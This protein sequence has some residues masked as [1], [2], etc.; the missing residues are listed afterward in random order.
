MSNADNAPSLDSCGC[1]SGEPPLNTI[2][3]RP[4]LNALAYRLG[5]Y[6]E[7]LQR[8][9][10]QI[11]SASI[12]E[13]PNQGS[14]PLAGL[15][16]RSLDDPSIALLDAWAIVADVLTF[17]QERIA[18]E[19]FLRTATDRRS[20]LELARAIG[21]ELN[22]GVAASAFLQFTVEEIIGSA[23]ATGATPGMRTPVPPGPGSS[24]F[25]S[26]I[27]DIP[28]G[29]QVQSV[30]APGKLPQTFE[31]AGNFQ[32]HAEWNQLSPR[33]SRRAD[34]AL[35]NGKLYLI[36]DSS[37]FL[38]G[39]FTWLPQA[40]VF[41]V[42]PPAPEPISFAGLFSHGLLN[43]FK[44]SVL[45]HALKLPVKSF[46]V[47]NAI[48]ALAP[49]KAGSASNKAPDILKLNTN[50]NTHLLLGGSGALSTLELPPIAIDI[51][52]PQVAAVEVNEI[53]L[54][55]TSTNLKAGDRMLLV[56]T[57]S[58]TGG[59]ATQAFIVRGIDVQSSLN[60]TLVEFTDGP[61]TP[62][63][64]PASF[65][66]EIV[67]EEKIPFSHSAVRTHILE[68][69]IGEGDLQIFLQMNGWKASDLVSMVN[70]PP[71]DPLGPDGAFAFRAYGGFFGHNAPVWKSLPDPA[72]SQR[73]D[74]YPRSW[75]GANNGTGTSVWTD[76]QSNLYQE[77]SVYLERSF[78]QILS[79]SWALFESKTRASAAYQITGVAEKSLSDYSMSGKSTGLTLN[80]SPDVAPYDSL[81]GSCTNNPAVVSWGHDRLDVF[82][83]GSGDHALYHKWW[84]GGA[85]GPSSTGFEYMGGVI[86]GDP[87]AVSWDHDRL[88]VF[89]VGTDGALYHKAW[90]GVQW[91]PSV[92]DYES[93]GI[94]RVGVTIRGNPVAVSWDHDRLDIFMTGT[95]GALYH[96]WWDGSQWG[97]SA[98]TFEFM[99]GEILGD[100]TV[101]SWDHDRLD[102]FV[103]GTDEGLYHKAW[104][105]TRWYPSVTDYENLGRP[106]TG[107][108]LA[109]NPVV[110]SWGHDRLD[111]FIVGTDGALYHKWW[112][113]SN[114][115]P[116]VSDFE[117]MSGGITRDPAVVSWDHDRLDVFVIGTDG[118]L[119]HKAWNGSQWSPS[120]T[121]YEFLSGYIIS[122][123]AVASWDH[124]RLDV[125]VIGGDGAL[126]H[127]AWDGT[128][129][130]KLNFPT[131]KTTAYVQSEQLTLVDFPIVDDISAGALELMLDN[132]V[133][134]LKPGQPVVISG[135]R[136]D[137]PAVAVSEVVLLSDIVHVGG[138]TVLKFGSG[139]KYSYLRSSVAINANVTLATH[140]AT[141]QEVLGNGDGSQ[142]NQ[143]FHLK[144]I[145]LTYVSAPTPSGSASSLQ[146]RV[147]D[148]EWEESE[149]FYGLG[150]ADEKYVVRLADD[151][152]PTLTFGDPAAR[153]RTGQQNIR[154]TYRTG[155]GLS[156]NV[157]AGS[158]SM[159]QSRPPGLRAVT[160][161]LA[162]SGGA[163]P[164][165][166]AHARR[167]APLTVLTLDR[168][169]SLDDYESFAQAFA[170]IGKAQAVAVWS[171]E[172]HLVHITVAQANGDPVDPVSPLY[173]TL[174]QAIQRAH[175]P[176]Q[177]FMVAAYQPL[178][179]NLTARLLI[180]KPRYIPQLVMTQVAETLKQ[181][182]SF[183][184]RSFAQAVTAAEIVALI[185]SVP[186]VIAS[187][188][189]QLYFTTDSS[190]PSQIE[191]PPFLPSVPAG[192]QGGAIRPAQLLLLNHLGVALTE[193]S[194]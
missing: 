139:L 148:L 170:G 181:A 44:S 179:F 7:F 49:V 84:D 177:S 110:N 80:F 151:G 132:M 152:T 45:S 176:V 83:V 135:L 131:R 125:F 24:A 161:P 14:Q 185:Q 115:G 138:F 68:K 143:S 156:G 39:T 62:S 22:P 15:T 33:L 183:E 128:S 165:D 87:V 174:L 158:L 56:G 162:A 4:G 53:Y 114:W 163:D 173:Q 111:V 21:Y 29:T 34:L 61:A 127:K 48:K 193:I 124:D 150:A 32:A 105:G 79:E 16:T 137:L 8:L 180:E 112:D 153:P 117:F 58:A 59:M 190:G 27:V 123:P 194:A 70:N 73:E 77:A 108:G 191:P 66:A 50:L 43:I 104:D 107:S 92:T 126:Y 102:V 81:G 38:P 188:L 71:A 178:S 5:T 18:N 166:L 26:G 168:I 187:T 9:L 86:V 41:L 106:S 60:R 19:G 171:G 109:R 164:Q 122:N 103:I 35:S 189:T 89:V 67:K 13:G 75:D 47:S 82:V 118:A 72:K 2:A 74:P 99:G 37:A 64:T 141:V 51:L 17:Y 11:R 54:Q 36:G 10:N 146:V 136:A 169:V 95:D 76:S 182:F 101:A 69:T 30:P 91:Q 88:D 142:T 184:N 134:G 98:T 20:V 145:P 6:G 147:N 130:G 119:Y 40:I 25:N 57:N 46:A 63:F 155:I 31:T 65:P 90:D 133:V 144:R 175:D 93:L 121:G 116:S 167:N 78:P 113:G 55:G 42:N 186:G 28:G 1:C 96:K 149:T 120:V 154:A 172:D 85:W 12:A 159:L 3:N 23:A 157:D 192:F 52:G 140:G 94:P 100:P 160:N 129:W 97:P